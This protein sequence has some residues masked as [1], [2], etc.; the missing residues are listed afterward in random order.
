M[1][2]AELAPARFTEPA[3]RRAFQ[4][5][6][7]SPFEL[8]EGGEN[9][10]C[11]IEML[12]RTGDAIPH[13]Y[14]GNI[15][16]DFAGMRHRKSIPVDYEHLTSDPIGV[17]NSFEIRNGDLYLLGSIESIEP[18]DAADKLMK[19]RSRGIP[20]QAS[21]FFDP[22][23]LE[24]EYI[25]QEMSAEVNGRNVDGPAVVVRSWDLRGVAVTP[26]GKDIG[27]ESVFSASQADA[28]NLNWKDGQ[29]S[30]T[31][32]KSADDKKPEDQDKP[33]EGKLSADDNKTE[34]TP[35]PLQA[36]RQQM[37]EFS[38]HFGKADA[39]EYFSAGLNL[40]QAALKHVGK[41]S[42]QVTELTA[43]RDKA[44]QQLAAAQ[45]SHGESEAVDTGDKKGKG[46]SFASMFREKGAASA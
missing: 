17:I 14:W 8:A 19:K 16:H 18:G 33:D 24:L 46:K 35:D 2:T 43:E 39:A 29:M 25:P 44:V 42:E 13:W 23:T 1:S 40:E 36:A 22:E 5:E 21:I 31:A 12:A 27:T 11:P 9:G 28:F 4:F 45:L 38:T 37:A 15:V 6:A 30:K 10:S 3:P 32:T 34:P 41:L 7:S 26:H 20:Y